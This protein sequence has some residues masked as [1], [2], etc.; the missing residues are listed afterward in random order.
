MCLTTPQYV[1][2]LSPHAACAGANMC[3]APKVIAVRPAMPTKAADK[4][5]PYCAIC[6]YIETQIE[7]QLQQN[8]T[9]EQIKTF[10]DNVCTK[11]P[12]AYVDQCVALVDANIDAFIGYIVN[13]LPPAFVCASIDLCPAPEARMVPLARAAPVKVPIVAESKIVAK[14]DGLYLTLP[15]FA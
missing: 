7:V 15:H 12:D 2:T 8:A 6:M 11:I 4:D 13:K 10:L 1:K 14:G 3:V 5:Y 9:E